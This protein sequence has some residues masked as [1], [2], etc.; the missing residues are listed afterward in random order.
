MGLIF[1]KQN[2]FNQAIE[3]YEKGIKIDPKYA[4]IYNNLGTVFKLKANYQKAEDYYKKSDYKGFIHSY[5]LCL[6]SGYSLPLPSER[7]LKGLVKQW[8]CSRSIS[9]R[10]KRQ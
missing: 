5:L 3:Y 8:P 9:P 4:M 2:E 6:S 7:T 1:A 10:Q